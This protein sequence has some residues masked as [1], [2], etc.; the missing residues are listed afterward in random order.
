M[1]A[2][3]VGGGRGCGGGGGG[4]GGGSPAFAPGGAPP[5]EEGSTAAAS[6]TVPPRTPSE[7]SACIRFSRCSSASH[8][9][10]QQ[11]GVGALRRAEAQGVAPRKARSPAPPILLCR[12]GLVLPSLGLLL[13]RHLLRLLFRTGRSLLRLPPR[14]LLLLL[15]PFRQPLRLAPRPL[16]LLVR[17]SLC[18]LRRLGR[19]SRCLA[20]LPR[21]LPLRLQRLAPRDGLGLLLLPELFHAD[22]LVQHRPTGELVDAPHHLQTRKDPLA[23]RVHV[24]L[25]ASRQVLEAPMIPII[26]SLPPHSTTSR[27]SSAMARASASGPV[28]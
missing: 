8:C 19:L 27:V 14:P 9:G 12:L 6:A 7:R 21:R 18:A 1:Y 10:G 2:G 24:D 22:L 17:L 26:D 25:V 11:A 4:G 13:A 23:V 3:V 5:G 16:P 20:L 28:G 15:C